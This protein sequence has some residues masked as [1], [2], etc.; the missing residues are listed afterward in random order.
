M[1]NCD[2]MRDGMR[3]SGDRRRSQE[4]SNCRPDVGAE[5]ER[6]DMPK[7]STVASANQWKAP[8]FWPPVVLMKPIWNTAM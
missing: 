8:S 5:R 4:R 2:L 3:G 7:I 6:V 1:R